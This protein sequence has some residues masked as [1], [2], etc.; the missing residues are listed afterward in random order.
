M[1]SFIPEDNLRFVTVN[2]QT[3]GDIFVLRTQASDT[4]AG[5]LSDS[6]IVSTLANFP[7]RLDATL[8]IIEDPQMKQLAKSKAE[9]HASVKLGRKYILRI[10][11]H[12]LQ[13]DKETVGSRLADADLFLQHPSADEVLPQVKYDNPHYLVRPGAEMVRLKDLQLEP[14]DDD[15]SSVEMEPDNKTGSSEL[16]RLFETAATDDGTAKVPNISPSP[17][18]RSALMR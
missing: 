18:L 12:G 11:I 10:V 6:R 4:Y 16:L 15:N 7:L 13:R 17:R 8:V 5:I 3:H 14:Y 9:K 1:S 2:L